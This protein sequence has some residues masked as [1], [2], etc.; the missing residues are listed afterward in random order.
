MDD[1]QAENFNYEGVR[2]RQDANPLAM[3]HF[4]E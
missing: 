1:Y 2:R 3:T 4:V